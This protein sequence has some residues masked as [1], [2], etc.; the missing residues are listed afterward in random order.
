MAAPEPTPRPKAPAA[1]PAPATTPAARADSDLVAHNR[2]LSEQSR[3]GATWLIGGRIGVGA[4]VTFIIVGALVLSTNAYRSTNYED[5]EFVPEPTPGARPAGIGLT[6]VGVGGLAA[7]VYA[8]VRG[9]R[10]TKAAQ[11]G[12]LVVGGDRRSA[13]IGYRARF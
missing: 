7:S 4:S 13:L 10:L 1:S 12:R 8:M 6:L 5:D 2:K 9:A 11:E 3:A